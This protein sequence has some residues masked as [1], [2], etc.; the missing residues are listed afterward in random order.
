MKRFIFI[1]VLFSI[2]IVPHA[3]ATSGAC[4]GHGGVSCSR[5]ADSLYDTDI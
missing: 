1:V 2:V 3:F 5:G 4:S